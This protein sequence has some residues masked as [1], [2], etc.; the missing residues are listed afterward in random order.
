MF[1]LFL[2]LMEDVKKG[3]L[4]K[5]FEMK[6][7]W[8]PILCLGLLSLPANAETTSVSAAGDQ[9]AAAV[10]ESAG[11][12]SAQSSAT[13][14]TGSATASDKPSF[15]SAVRTF[16]ERRYREAMTQFKRL[17]QTDERVQYYL[18]RCAQQMNQV[19]MARS[20]FYFVLTRAKDPT[21]KANART[22]YDQLTYYAAHRTYEG[23]GN[24]FQRDS[25]PGFA[26]SSFS[27]S[28]GSG[29]GSA[30]GGGTA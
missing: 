16:N 10:Q 20:H 15:D 9:A 19:G 25:R 26:R 7:Y 28:S 30:G 12:Q 24:V 8:L 11:S 21:L 29:G 1:E 14:S 22:A 4:L 13:A 3:P 6:S 18:G 27:G 2:V 5:V 23:N 17:P